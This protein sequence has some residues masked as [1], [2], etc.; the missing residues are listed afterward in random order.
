MSGL[1]ILGAGGHGLVV[2][3][4]AH[5][6]ARWS[7]IA[8][9]DDDQREHSVDDVWPVVGAI[10]DIEQFRDKFSELATFPSVWM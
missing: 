3:D 2:A 10:S 7:E 6:T 4:A 8:F 1:L 9:L 5:E